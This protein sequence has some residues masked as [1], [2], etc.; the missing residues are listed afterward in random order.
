[1]ENNQNKQFND[2]SDIVYILEVPLMSG[3]IEIIWMR[4]SASACNLL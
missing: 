4:T 2:K 3:L 1:M